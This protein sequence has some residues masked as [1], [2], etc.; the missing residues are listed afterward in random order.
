M[1]EGR[2]EVVWRG[3]GEGGTVTE[4]REEMADEAEVEEV[5][6]EREEVNADGTGETSL[7]CVEVDARE[8]AVVAPPTT[9]RTVVSTP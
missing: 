1:V 6:V 2:E 4:A 3:F 9:R 7:L 8:G 5:P